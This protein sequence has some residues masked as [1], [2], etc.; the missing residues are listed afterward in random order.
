MHSRAT[1]RPPVAAQRARPLWHDLWSNGQML[2]DQQPTPNTQVAVPGVGVLVL[3]EQVRTERPQVPHPLGGFTQFG[4]TSLVV[5]A[6]R[7][8]ENGSD[9][10][11]D[12]VL[13]QSQ[14]LL[15]GPAVTI[16]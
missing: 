8:H 11:S 4:E 12:I 7:L 15:E 13:S 3:N 2:L 6:A 9:P 5:T 14:C 1:A 10:A 16:R